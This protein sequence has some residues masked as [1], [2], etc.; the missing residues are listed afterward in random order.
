MTIKFAKVDDI[1]IG[2]EI[3]TCINGKV[4]TRGPVDEI[5]Y[6]GTSIVNGGRYIGG[7]IQFGDARLSFSFNE[8]RNH[9]TVIIDN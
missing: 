5:T 2:V 3:G 4:A 1:E 9:H 6:T 8:D 7:Y